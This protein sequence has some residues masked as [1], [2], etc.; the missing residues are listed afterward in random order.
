APPAGRRLPP[1]LKPR[2]CT[3]ARRP[4]ATSTRPPSTSAPA[5]ATVGESPGRAPASGNVFGNLVIATPGNPSL[6]Q[7]LFS[8]AI[9]GFAPRLIN[10]SHGQ[11]RSQPVH[12]LPPPVRHHRP[13]LASKVAVL[14]AK[15]RHRGQP[16]SLLLKQS[17]SVSQL[18]SL[19]DY[20]ARRVSGFDGP[21]S[22]SDCLKGSRVV[23][24]PAGVPR[25]P[26]MTRDDLFNTNAGIVADLITAVAKTCPKAMICIVTNPVN[27]TVPIAAEILKKHN[28]YDPRRLFGV[29]TT[30]DIVRSNA[31]VA[32]AKGLD[33]SKTPGEAVE[34][35]LKQLSTTAA[36][37]GE[38]AGDRRAQR[39]H[40]HP[41][42]QPGGASVSFK[43][44]DRET[45][46]T[47]IQNAG[48]EVVNAKAG[49]GSATLS[50]AFA[51][52]KFVDSVLQAIDGKRG[53]IE[54][55]FV[56]STVTEAPYFS[57]PLLLGRDGVEEN[58]GLGN[59]I[60]F[61]AKLLQAAM[62]ELQQNIAKGVK[63]VKERY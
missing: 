35:T 43:A 17:A 12:H 23:V 63:F 30:L 48:T 20:S 7:Q 11:P 25:K 27:S 10:S 47:R 46:T 58:L 42:D 62:P 49:A 45:L 1:V 38:R 61:E 4:A 57:T 50:M 36:L 60:E 2:S 59:L 44:Q 29:T 51:A 5:A 56:E 8:Y 28:A 3:P 6:K 34:W 37:A 41:S 18:S 55:A 19:Y 14:G 32:E 31:F 15:R 13:S 52:E 54:C 9:L 21:A 39:R 24:I 33:V 40:D 22:L 26:G 16:L 53:V